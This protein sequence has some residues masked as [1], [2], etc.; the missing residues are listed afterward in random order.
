MEYKIGDRVGTKYF[1]CK[2]VHEGKMLN[3]DKSDI[4]TK[5]QEKIISQEDLDS[6]KEGYITFPS[7]EDS[8]RMTCVP[9]NMIIT[10]YD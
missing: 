5:V 9:K 1:V 7:L 6:L 4:E 3:W 2:T 10:L 8:R